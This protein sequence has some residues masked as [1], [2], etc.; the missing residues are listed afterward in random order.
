MVHVPLQLCAL[1]CSHMKL[2]ACQK[3]ITTQ[4]VMHAE[5]LARTPH[6]VRQIEME[7]M[8]F[9][10]Q[11]FFHT[12]IIQKIQKFTIIP[13]IPNHHSRGRRWR[14]ILYLVEAQRWSATSTAHWRPQPF[15]TVLH[16]WSCY[17]RTF[18][19][20]TCVYERAKVQSVKAKAIDLLL[21]ASAHSN[22]F[23]RMFFE[24][25]E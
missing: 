4:I 1:Y 19:A 7:S 21:Q 15:G 20:V 9:F 12:S 3:Y 10:A 17:S 16:Q 13:G 18:Q 2:A 23:L 8:S 25:Q 24:M 6:I 22:A 5:Y 14:W 11:L